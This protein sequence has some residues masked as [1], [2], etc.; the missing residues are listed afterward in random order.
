MFIFIWPQTIQSAWN[1]VTGQ[2][3]NSGCLALKIVAIL[4]LEQGIISI[5]L[6]VVVARD[7]AA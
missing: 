4:M 5:G 7:I 2:I 3:E 6:N 1:T